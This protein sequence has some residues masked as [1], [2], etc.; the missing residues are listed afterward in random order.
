MKDGWFAVLMIA[1]IMGLAL[2]AAL[3]ANCVLL[4]EICS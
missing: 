1:L 3:L 2:G 4:N